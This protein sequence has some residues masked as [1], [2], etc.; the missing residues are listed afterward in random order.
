MKYTK[1]F[2]YPIYI[3]FG[4]PKEYHLPPLLYTI[5]IFF[6]DINFILSLVKLFTFADDCKFLGMNL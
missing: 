2:S 4:V 3:S 6:N 5:Y 1:F